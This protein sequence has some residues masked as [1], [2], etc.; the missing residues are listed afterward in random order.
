MHR[1]PGAQVQRGR[2]AKHLEDNDTQHNDIHHNNTQ[3]ND[4]QRNDKE[5]ATHSI[6]LLSKMTHSIITL[7]VI[8]TQHNYP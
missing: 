3:H 7:R 5:N 6:M 1:L 4:I 8:D 2:L